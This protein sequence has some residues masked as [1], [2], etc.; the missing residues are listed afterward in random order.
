MAEE[1]IISVS[2][3]ETRVAVVEQGLMQEIFLERSH[4]PGTVGNVYKGKVL[5]VLPGMQS[6]FVDIGHAKAAF[7]HV[8]DLIDTHEAMMEKRGRTLQCCPST[9]SCTRARSCWFR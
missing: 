7:L 6:A 1:I 2:P 5:R 4:T 9:N 3:H 8:T